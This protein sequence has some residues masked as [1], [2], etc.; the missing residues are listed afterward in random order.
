[1]MYVLHRWPSISSVH[2]VLRTRVLL[3]LALL[4]R[5]ASP[6]LRCAESAS[7][8]ASVS[9]AKK[10][11]SVFGLA[12]LPPAVVKVVKLSSDESDDEE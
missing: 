3:L 9:S 2:F 12:Q 6:G 4:A 11:A 1:M 5:V 7:A 8:S 10:E